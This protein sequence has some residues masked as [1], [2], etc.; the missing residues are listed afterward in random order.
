[1]Y[2]LY[3][4]TET[5]ITAEGIQLHVENNYDDVLF[6]HHLPYKNGIETLR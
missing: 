3:R 1:M 6:N 2:G 5:V 4:I